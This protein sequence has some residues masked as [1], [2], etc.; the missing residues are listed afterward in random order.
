MTQ[1]S[2]L[3]MSSQGRDTAQ[4]APQTVA[5]PNN[6]EIMPTSMNNTALTPAQTS[7]LPCGTENAIFQTSA[8]SEIDSVTSNNIHAS[9][10]GSPHVITTAEDLKPLLKERLPR[11]Q[12]GSAYRWYIRGAADFGAQSL[13]YDS[14][15]H[16]APGSAVDFPQ[17]DA[18]L[19]ALAR[20]LAEAMMDM[21]DAVEAGKKS[22][23]R[24]KQISPYEIELKSWKLLFILRDVQLGRVDLHLWGA[25]WNMETFETFMDRYED[26]RS[27]LRT[28]KSL[29]SSL[30]DQEFGVRLALAPG[31]ELKKKLANRT[32]LDGPSSWRGSGTRRNAPWSLAMM[33]KTMSKRRS[34]EQSV[35]IPRHRIIRASPRHHSVLLLMQMMEPPRAP[36][37]KASRS[38]T[39]KSIWNWR[40]TMLFSMHCEKGSVIA[41]KK[42]GKVSQDTDD[43]GSSQTKT[44]RKRPIWSHGVYCCLSRVFWLIKVFGRADNTMVGCASLLPNNT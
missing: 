28:S 31:S 30:F 40:P 36:V 11:E 20:G 43:Y 5:T 8:A 19:V 7:T 9:F 26:V 27:N 1:M 32:I 10:F 34:L 38:R 33:M 41:L 17:D 16:K 12:S 39:S 3:E 13:L 42:C 37:I 24:I 6:T 15:S 29:V 25:E 21:T 18:G 2:V 23:A 44:N 14:L 35:L 22:V 4:N